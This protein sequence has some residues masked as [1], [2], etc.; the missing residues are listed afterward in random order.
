MGSLSRVVLAVTLIACL[1]APLRAHGGGHVPPPS[2]PGFGPSDAGGGIMAP[3]GPGA[4]SGRAGATSG[5]GG[6]AGIGPAVTGATTGVRTARGGSDRR[7]GAST[8]SAEYRLVITSW[9]F[10]WVANRNAYLGLREQLGRRLVTSGS[11]GALTGRGRQVTGGSAHGA[12]RATVDGVVVPAL[13]DILATSDERDMLD[14]AALAAA[15]SVSEYGSASVRDALLPLLGHRDQTVQSAATLSLGVLGDAEARPALRALLRDDSDGRA[16]AGGNVPTLTRS[17]AA[18]S[19]GLIGKAV[20]ARLLAQI[21][22]R[23]PDSEREVKAAC[24]MSLG[25]LG[26][27][28]SVTAPVH[29][30]LLQLLEDER[31][32]PMVRGHVPTA[33]ARTGDRQLLPALLAAYRD[34][35]APHTVLRSVTFAFGRLATPADVDVVQALLDRLDDGGELHVRQLALI[36]LG[37][38]GARPV[39]IPAGDDPESAAAV[40]AATEDAAEARER[41][42]RALLHR[43][44]GKGQ[45]ANRAWGALGAA[46]CARGHGPARARVV[47]HLRAAYEDE[48]E[49]STK[50]AIAIAL[51]LVDDRP[52]APALLADLQE[53]RDQRFR[54]H[55]G[56]ALG[57][58]RH[59]E[60][61]ESLRNLLL[62]PGSRTDLRVECAIGLGLLGDMSSLELLSEALVESQT[63]GAVGGLAQ[64]VGLVGTTTAVAPL[65]DLARDGSR[66]ALA[67]G[68]ACVALGLLGARR[69]LSFQAELLAHEDYASESEALQKLMALL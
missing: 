45:S 32:D 18:F 7:T 62:Q 19:L 66:P 61:T 42:L 60:A 58:L 34:R 51:G 5:R 37:E 35:D 31:L 47:E 17:F 63:L 56:V 65:L 27:N 22:E 67:R 64:A 54:G 13:L 38:I 46:L 12:D 30:R 59:E 44:D 16:L 41:L 21:I 68:F 10:W 43:V 3:A 33:L 50:S 14:S 49:P 23:S 2:G 9:E 1:G 69:D 40:A 20:D 36:A 8:G 52:S 53:R 15:R 39:A 6:A 55:A 26:A 25:L 57:M 24:L 29:D 11:V 48:N 4:G 28:G